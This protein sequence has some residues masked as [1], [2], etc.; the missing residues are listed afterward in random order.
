MAKK[1]AKK[2]KNGRIDVKKTKFLITGG[3]GSFG[4]NIIKKLLA[5]GATNIISISRDE[6]LI[7]QAEREIGSNLVKFKIGD[8]TH[9]E[10]IENIMKEVDVVFHAAALKHVSLSEQNP[11]ETYRVNVLG[12]LNLLNAS[13]SVK[14]FIHISSD[15]AIGVM[16][17]YGA[18]KL[19]GEYLVKE[20]NDLHNKNTYIITRCPNL[21][22]SRGSVTD[23][24][25][26]QL[27]KYNK[28]TITDPDMT[29]YFVTLSDASDFILDV[30]LYDTLDSGKIYYPMKYT[31]K[32]KLGDLAEAFLKINGNKNSSVEIIGASPGEKKHEDYMS[33]VPLSSVK[34]LISILRTNIQ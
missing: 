4:R 26:G 29:R 22:G 20:S 12:L 27:S 28:I 14:R 15:K 3:S 34:E 13:S 23:I 30:G 33:D 19:L 24:W 25:S 6:N 17:C 1:Q 18:T 32:Y 5:I 10:T 21:L 16:N 2:T 8:I 7:K 31:K 11:R 9:Q